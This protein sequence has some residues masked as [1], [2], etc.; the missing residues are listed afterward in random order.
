MKKRT[1]LV[2]FMA[3][4][5]LAASSQTFDEWFRQE[6]TQ[7]AYLHQQLAALRV[8]GDAL[9]NGYRIARGGI[10]TIFQTKRDDYSL[11]SNFLLSLRRVG[12]NVKRYQ[13]IPAIV[14]YAT[15]ITSKAK[16]VIRDSRA[17]KQ[18]TPEEIS[19]STNVLQTLLAECGKMIDELTSVIASGEREMSD[20]QRIRRIDAIYT[21]VQRQYSFCQAFAGSMAMLS[22]QRA[23]EQIDINRSKTINGLR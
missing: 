15:K 23:A 12:E 14:S 16:G 21:E 4:G 1:L 11:H 3:G 7:K 5:S 19:H 17:G 9:S 6:K 13:K 10:D 8:F 2:V 20:E 22:Q 18:L